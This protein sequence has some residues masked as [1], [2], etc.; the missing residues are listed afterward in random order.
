MTAEQL[1][2]DDA[3]DRKIPLR[4][5]GPYLSERQGTVRDTTASGMPGLPAIRLDPGLIAGEG[6]PR[7]LSD[8][9]QRSPSP[10]PV[11][12]Q[13]PILKERLSN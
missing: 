12:Q 7:G 11:E 1:R 3:R 13:D 4:K 2:L 9:Q 10:S 6:R 5:W 8:D